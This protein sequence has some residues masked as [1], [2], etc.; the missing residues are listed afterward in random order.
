MK[1]WDVLFSIPYM[2]D[3]LGY[4]LREA[5]IISLTTT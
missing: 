2:D 3:G 4:Y 5:S 1:A